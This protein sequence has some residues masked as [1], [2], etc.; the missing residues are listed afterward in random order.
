MPTLAVDD[1]AMHYTDTERDAPSLAFIHGL[2]SSGRDWKPQVEAFASDF[3]VLTCDLRGHGH[4]SKPDGPYSIAQLARDVAVWLRK[5]DATPAHVVGLSMG[6]MVTYE[7]LAH[8]P[9]VVRSGM[10]INSV[11]SVQLNG[12]SDYAFYWSRRG[13]VQALGMRRVGRLLARKLFIKSGQQELRTQFIERWAENDKRAYLASIDGLVGWSVEDQLP[14]ISHPVLV[15]TAD[16]DYTP[17][18]TKRKHARAMPNAQLAVI[19]DTRHALPVERPDSVNA[20]LRAFME[21][22]EQRSTDES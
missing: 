1:I 18:S 10:I 5:V 16:D 14:T 7:L 15:L 9:K 3:R 13:A 19:A 21:R 12:L 22:V 20:L 2:G 11:P 17:A 4:T 6:G 8:T